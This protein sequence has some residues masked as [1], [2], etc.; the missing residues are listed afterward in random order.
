MSGPDGRL[1]RHHVSLLVKLSIFQSRCPSWGA[2]A[3]STGPPRAI[4]TENVAP[5]SSWTF[6]SNLLFRD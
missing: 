2:A 4:L 6:R 1:R 3:G 5:E